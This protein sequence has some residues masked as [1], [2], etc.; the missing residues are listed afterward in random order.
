MT[1]VAKGLKPNDTEKHRLLQHIKKLNFAHRVHIL[2]R[3]SF[4]INS[5][6]FPKRH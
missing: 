3:D 4:K 6:H 1:L 5:Y 2:F